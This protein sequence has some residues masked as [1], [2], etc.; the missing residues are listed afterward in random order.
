MPDNFPL[1]ICSAKMEA[2]PDVYQ[3]F[4]NERYL[5]LSMGSE[6]FKFKDRN[7]NENLI[8]RNEDEMYKY[9]TQIE[10]FEKC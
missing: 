9:D 4:L 7:I 5:S 10:M 3:Q 8:F 6:N 1:P 2:P